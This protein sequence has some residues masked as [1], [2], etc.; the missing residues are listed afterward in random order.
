MRSNRDITLEDARELALATLRT[1]KS[2]EELV[3]L[4]ARTIEK[5][6]GWVFFYQSRRFVE[7]GDVL[8]A[9]GGNGPL[10]IERDSGRITVLGT[11]RGV[12]EELRVFEECLTNRS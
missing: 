5:P 6:Y 10:V 7:T 11:A 12:E 4:E 8:H 1:F 2:S 9:L 3:L